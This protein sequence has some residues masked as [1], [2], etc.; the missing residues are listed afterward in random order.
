MQAWDMGKAIPNKNTRMETK[1][2]AVNVQA[3]PT[4]IA[5]PPESNS[6]NDVAGQSFSSQLPDLNLAALQP[7]VAIQVARQSSLVL[8]E[9]ITISYPL[10]IWCSSQKSHSA[11]CVHVQMR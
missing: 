9:T 11:Q 4:L 7:V 5:Q 1:F 10:N 3:V 6:P 2:H 8:S